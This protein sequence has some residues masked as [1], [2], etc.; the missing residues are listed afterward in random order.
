VQNDKAGLQQITEA[1]QLQSTSVESAEER[2]KALTTRP[3]FSG[4]VKQWQKNNGVRSLKTRVDGLVRPA[5]P[6]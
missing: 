1:L 6:G 3:M 2:A 5:M 4:T